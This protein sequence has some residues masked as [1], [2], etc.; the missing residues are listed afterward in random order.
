MISPSFITFAAKTLEM[1]CDVLKYATFSRGLWL[2]LCKTCS[3]LNILQWNLTFSLLT[4]LGS[5]I[6]LFYLLVH[7]TNFLWGVFDKIWM[8]RYFAVVN[9]MVRKFSFCSNLYADVIANIVLLY[10]FI[11]LKIAFN[12]WNMILK[13]K[14]FI[15]IGTFII[16]KKRLTSRVAINF[17][18][19][20]RYCTSINHLDTLLKK[21]N[22]QKYSLGEWI[23][24]AKS[25]ECTFL[26]IPNK[27]HGVWMTIFFRRSVFYTTLTIGLCGAP[28]I[29]VL[30]GSHCTV[31]VSIREFRISVRFVLYICA[32]KTTMVEVQNNLSFEASDSKWHCKL[33]MK[34]LLQ[35]AC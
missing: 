19:E 7:T 13:L 15:Q 28:K 18:D 6:F 27:F 29:S 11:N 32:F 20:T 2:A 30:R 31:R 14:S 34:H 22:T 1:Y 3:F 10:I 12:P 5:P 26:Y 25:T 35:L 9:Y 17:V 21:Y 16:H 24:L 33:F 8:I 23:L 4:W